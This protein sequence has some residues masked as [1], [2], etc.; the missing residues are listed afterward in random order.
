M[1][2]EPIADWTPDSGT[3]PYAVRWQATTAMVISDRPAPSGV[4]LDWV[5]YNVVVERDEH[6]PDPAVVV[7]TA[8]SI[9]LAAHIQ[10]PDDE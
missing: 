4:M 9:D 2:N 3:D 8:P 10:A 6:A 5:R 1:S 7:G